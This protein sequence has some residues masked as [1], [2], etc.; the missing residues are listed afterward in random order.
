[1]LTLPPAG[2][3]QSDMRGSFSEQNSH[4][5]EKILLLGTRITLIVPHPEHL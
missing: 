3:L 2:R 4:D 1:M 5:R